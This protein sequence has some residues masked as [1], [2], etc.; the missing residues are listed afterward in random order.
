MK[1]KKRQREALLEWIAEGLESDEINKRAAKFKPP[2][3]VLRTQV[4]YYR[5]SRQ[6]HLEEIKE[7]GE[8][9]ALTTG[10]ALRGERVK[11]LKILADKMLKELQESDKWWL[12]QVKGIGQGP[13]FE[14]VAYFEFNKSELESF[15]GILDDIAAEVGDRI[16]RVDATSDGEALKII[17]VGLDVDKL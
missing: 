4:T 10:L 8:V 11:A 13:N 17:R 9:D 7:S 16:K 6:H 12:P 14:R 5:N 2:F 3:R 15:R 1:L